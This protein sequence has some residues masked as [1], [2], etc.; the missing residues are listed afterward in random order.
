MINGH[1]DDSYQFLHPI[2]SNFSSNVYNRTPLNGLKTYLCENMDSI[3]HYP[4]PAPYTLEKQLATYH[5]LQA[6]EVCVTNGCTEAIYLIAQTFRESHSLV[7]QPTFTEYADACRLHKH[8]LSSFYQWPTAQEGFRLPLNQGLCWLCNPNN[9]TGEVVDPSYLRQLIAHNPQVCF[10]IDQSYEAFTLHPLFSAQE[11]AEFPQVLLLHSMTKK[12]AIP[13]LRLG[14][15]TGNAALLEK[16]RVHRMPWSVNQL[17]ICAGK[18]LLS[19]ACELQLPLPQ[20]LQ[21]TDHLRQSLKALGVVDVWDTDTHFLLCSLRWGT[22]ASL[23]Q[24]LAEKHGILIR[25]A[26][27]FVGLDARYFRIAT[28]TPEENAQLIHAIQ[29]WIASEL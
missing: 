25:D 6:D 27:N 14:Y 29:A 16:I 1:G 4:E 21:E 15:V 19:H 13:G 23:K 10:I 22:A 8:T 20:L 12:Y 24:Y 7:F 3:A 5:H 17:A 28:Q 18:Y 26:S 2:Q 11:A 9:P